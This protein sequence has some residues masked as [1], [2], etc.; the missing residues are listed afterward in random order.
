MKKNHRYLKG[1]LV[2]FAAALPAHADL[3]WDGNDTGPDADGG[4]GVWDTSTL[5]WDDQAVAGTSVVWN[6]AQAASFGGTAGTVSIASGGITAAGL[7]FGTDGYVLQGNS[8]TP[9]AP[10][11]VSP[12][13]GATIGSA[14][15]GTG[16]LSKGGAGTLTLAGASTFTGST[17]ITAG[18]LKLSPLNSYRYYR[19]TAY[20]NYGNGS[21]SAD[22]Y[23][24]IGELH[25]YKAGVWTAATTGTASGPGTGEQLW[26]NANDN[27]GANVAG[28]TKYGFGTRPIVITYDF[29]ASTSFDAYNWSSANDSTPA[30]NPRRWIISGS[31]DNTNFTT[32]D[33][34]SAIEQVGPT[35][36]Y[37]WSSPTGA[38]ATVDNSVTGGAAGAYPIP[39][40]SGLP[41]GSGLEIASGATL[42]LNGVSQI[43]AS[44]ADLSG[45]GGAIINS[46]AAKR[47]VLNVGSSNAN[48]VYSGTISDSGTAGSISFVKVG[49]GSLTLGGS[50][51]NTYTGVTILGSTGKLLLAKTGGATAIPANLEL[52][53]TAFGGNN[54]GVVLGGD[55]QIADGALL[56]WTMQGYQTTTQAESFFRLN[57]HTE[58]VGGLVSQN[59]AATGFP[60]IENRGQNDASAYA[61]GN[62]TINV[63][64]SGSTFSY[65]GIIRDTDGNLNSQSGKIAITKTGPGTQLLGGNMSGCTGPAIVNNGVLRINNTL[66]AATVS[67]TGTGILQGTGGTLTGLVTVGSGGIISPGV[68]GAGTLTTT[69]PV[70]VATGGTV[71]PLAGTTLGG[72]VVVGSGGTLAGLGTVSG[73]VTIQSG[74]QL[75]PGNNT[76]GTLNTNGAVTLAGNATFEINKTGATL[77]N[78]KINNFSQITYGGTLTIVPTGDTP[79]LGDSFQLF[80]PSGTGTFAGGFASISGLPTLPGGL[81][82]ETSTL[83]SNGRITVVNKANTPAFSPTGG[84]QIGAQSVTITSDSGSTIY[85]TL[86]GSDPTLASA[87]GTSPITGITIPVDSVVVLKAFATST[88]FADSAIATATYRTVTV[89]KWDVDAAGNWSLA[90]N[91]ANQVIPNGVDSPVDFTKPQT[92]ARIVTLDGAR[93]VGSLSFGNTN[94][95]TWTLSGANTLTLA[96]TSG[97]PGIAVQ[98]VDTTISS[99]LAGVQGLIKSG[100]GTLFVTGTNTYS[101]NTAINGGVLAASSLATNGTNSSLGSGN[102]LSI[103]GGTLRYTTT[104]TNIGANTF[105]RAVTLG[106]GGG[107]LDGLTGGFWFTTGTFSGSGSLTKIGARQLII[108]SNNTYDG[109]TFVNQEEVQFRTLD[110]FGSLVGKTI[111]SASNNARV[112]AGGAVTG[113][114]L[115]NFE[116]NGLG[117]GNGALQAN[118]GGT[119]I[120]YGGNIV[121]ASTS[122]IGGGVGFVISGPIS[123]AGGLTKVSANSVTLSGSTSNTYAGDTT[124][125]STGRLLLAKTG[126]AIAIPGNVNLSATNWNGNSAGVVLGGNEQIA[127]GAVIT[128]TAAAFPSGAMA[129][130]FLRLNGFTETVGGLVLAAG[131][132]TIEN[133]GLNDTTAYGTGT[134]VINTTGA[135]SYTFNGGI[136]NV[137]GG[138]GGGT[139]AIT[140]TGTG[141]QIF[142]GTLMSYTGPTTVNQGT[143]Q[144]N[145]TGGASPITVNAG[146]TLK[147]TGSTSA[148]LTV[149]AGGTIAPGASAGAY[150][151]GNTI[152]DGTYVCEIDGASTDRLTVNGD[153]DIAGAIVSFSTL[154][155]PTATSYVIASYTGTL[156]GV[157]EALN[158]PEG[159]EVHHFPAT[160]Q[161]V[162]RVIP[163]GFA[164]YVESNGLS[165][166]PSADFDGD[167]LADAVEYVLGTSPTQAGSTGPT[168]ELVGGNFVFSFTRDH[169]SLTP[170]ITV[171]VETSP[172]LA[173]WP[174]AYHVGADTA[175]SDAGIT[176]TNNGTNDT[177]TLSIPQGTDP[178]K[179]ARLKV[180]VKP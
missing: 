50:T 88:G 9:T 56:T 123:G 171:T 122:G 130:S 13:V 65:W 157:F 112:A 84:S 152:I 72:A 179:V 156:T 161:I 74:G 128:W 109:D 105:N 95:F 62:L 40:G 167:G 114:I 16:G 12:S 14:I 78:D 118:D 3:F 58:T 82:W 104:G 76:I 85:Y 54:A 143:L 162:L 10:I 172:D 107:T 71:L 81:Q 55:E 132:G 68:S 35:A 165:G 11:L 21:T 145:N 18:T 49:T 23:N 31:N 24:Q 103:D 170:D 137:D 178:M 60:L 43:S 39:G 93:T 70:N 97:T 48:T 66:A 116:L 57:G 38:F 83:T 115:E 20:T 166:D 67:V 41:V 134:L 120:N 8:L 17:K 33:D 175:S 5:N 151:A 176:V 155:A 99:V 140:K 1:T 89:P 119:T 113:T 63:V 44:L 75:S 101:G 51:S 47:V 96:T 138:T 177:V 173:T 52:S 126:G 147:G 144:L 77:T 86:D 42:D 91:W 94:P 37:N 164:A 158:L 133:R 79:V 26:S 98:N 6:S 92:A 36:T 111:V 34:R 64:N 131:P 125:G 141:T 160:K 124:L 153:L 180:A 121:L 69:N 149:N 59:T 163:T 53:S 148:S 87:S 80:A 19:F 146:G 2:L 73:A 22:G 45:G 29:G 136:R 102:S 100:P 110:A 174:G 27:K 25:Y 90:T 127:D 106:A 159:W 46:N 168:L 117:G 135:S 30:R 7:S 154:N 129:E 4:V 169:A 142:G 28:F 150:T 139:V 15:A 108:Q 61:N 32:L